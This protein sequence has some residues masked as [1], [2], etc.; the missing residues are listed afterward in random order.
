[1]KTQKTYMSEIVCVKCKLSFKKYNKPYNFTKKQKQTAE[2]NITGNDLP[3]FMQ[4]HTE[5][6]FR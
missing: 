6:V 1:M 2:K 3:E 4:R 5:T